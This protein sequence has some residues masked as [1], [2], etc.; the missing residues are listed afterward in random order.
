MRMARESISGGLGVKVIRNMGIVQ[1]KGQWWVETIVAG[2]PWY[3]GGY[4]KYSDAYA[5]MERL[6]RAWQRQRSYRA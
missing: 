2:R 5:H 6:K 3:W 1:I 4:A